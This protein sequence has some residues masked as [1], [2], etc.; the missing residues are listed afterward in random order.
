MISY[1]EAGQ[2]VLNKYDK[3]SS[4]ISVLDA[5]SSWIV[6]IA[7]KNLSKGEYVLDAN[8]KVNKLTGKVSEYSTVM[9]PEEFKK[10]LKL[11]VYKVKR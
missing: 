7:P 5:G 10:A 9:N 11:E 8:F 2:L 3:N 4:V 1:K 6:S